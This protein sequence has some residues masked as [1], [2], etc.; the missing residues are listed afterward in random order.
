MSSPFTKFRKNQKKWMAFLG[1][2]CMVSFVFGGITCNNGM[3]P[4]A[5]QI[6]VSTSRGNYTEYALGQLVQTRH[7][8]NRFMYRAMVAAG[9]NP[10]TDT[11]FG[12]ADEES[13]LFGF[14]LADRAQQAGIRITDDTVNDYIRQQTGGNLSNDQVASILD[15]QG[16]SPF[17]LYQSLRRELTAL[18]LYQRYVSSSAVTP[19]SQ[20]WDY[21]LRMHEQATVQVLPIKVDAFI[22]KITPPSDEVLETFFQEHK[23]I[24]ANP[25]SSE[26]GFAQ[27][28]RIAIQ[29]VKAKFETFYDAALAAVTEEDIKTYYD[30]H[31]KEFPYMAL[32]GADFLDAHGLTPS[33]E[34][35]PADEEV[36]TPSDLPPGESATPETNKPA[37]DKPTTDKPADDKP[38]DDKPADDKPADSKPPADKPADDK[39]TTDN[40]PATDDKPAAP[41]KPGKDDAPTAPQVDEKP[42]AEEQGRTDLPNDNLLAFAGSAELLLAQNETSPAEPEEKDNKPAS[43]TA[44][45]A[46]PAADPAKPATDG[47]KPAEDTKPDAD[48]NT[49]DESGEKSQAPP[50]KTLDDLAAELLPPTDVTA[51]PDPEYDPLWKVEGR[52]RETLARQR[53]N[54]KIEAGMTEITEAMD[55]YA[56]VWRDWNVQLGEKDFDQPEPKLPD[57]QGMASKYGF[58]LQPHT[59]LHTPYWYR[60]NSE[61]GKS[62]VNQNGFDQSFLGVA[63][64]GLRMMQPAVATTEDGDKFLFWKVREFLEYVPDSITDNRWESDPSLKGY[65][66]K[67][68]LPIKDQVVQSWKL[69]E[70]RDF[71][72]KKAEEVAEQ[73]RKSEKPLT[74]ITVEGETGEEIPPFTWMTASSAPSFQG[75]QPAR[76][77]EVEGVEAAGNTFMKDVFALENGQVGVAFNQPENIAYVVKRVGSS[78]VL[79]GTPLDSPQLARTLFMTSD[80]RSYMQFVEQQVREQNQAL[81]EQINQA[82]KVDWKRPPRTIER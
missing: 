20:R 9:A 34:P 13:V 17:E 47:A 44:D 24:Q 29:T 18:E 6:A 78:F 7:N 72:K 45:P 53:A 61:I 33:G 39:P 16:L 43:A 54:E 36:K 74:E 69:I 19:P 59:D 5:N 63:F 23:N 35:K 68:L 41:E 21:Y 50:V 80:R 30:E 57:L 48:T 26:P 40:K 71:A 32:S 76:L 60:E 10:R 79:G 51:G 15:Q 31:Q 62:T 52:I 49:D 81:N 4:Q 70:A 55:E 82:Y 2:A 11:P 56:S 1:V 27:P 3:T 12:P 64:Y 65:L 58:E 75:P 66:P 67:D 38:A 28:R 77:T 8:V 22:D 73:A 42:G 37:T 46:K 25:F 14:L